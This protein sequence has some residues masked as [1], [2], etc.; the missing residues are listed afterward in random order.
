LERRDH[1]DEREGG[2][3]GDGRFDLGEIIPEEL[4]GDVN[5]RLAD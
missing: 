4:R 3:S 5:L 1:H 2:S